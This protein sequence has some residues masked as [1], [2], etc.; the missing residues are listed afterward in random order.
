MEYYNTNKNGLFVLDLPTVSP[1]ARLHFPRTHQAVIFSNSVTPLKR[2]K[3]KTGKGRKPLLTQHPWTYLAFPAGLK[4][5]VEV[6]VVPVTS[7]APREGHHGRPAQGRLPTQM[8]D[9]HSAECITKR[10]HVPPDPPDFHAKHWLYGLLTYF[11]E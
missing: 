10:D 3:T 2:S 1:Q 6:A 11:Q 9:K 8:T 7:S 5:T 4:V